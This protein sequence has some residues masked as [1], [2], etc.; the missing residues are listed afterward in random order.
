MEHQTSAL[1]RE[2]ARCNFV[3]E[4]D[5]GPERLEPLREKLRV[6]ARHLRAVADG[7]DGNLATASR[8]LW[9]FSLLPLTYIDDL[10]QMLKE[11]DEIV[12]FIDNWFDCENRDHHSGRAVIRGSLERAEQYLRKLPSTPEIEQAIRLLEEQG[13]ALASKSEQDRD[14][15]RDTF[16]EQVVLPARKA[17]DDAF[18]AVLDLIDEIQQKAPEPLR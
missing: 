4:H 2:H 8:R 12:S 17:L 6:A 5:A 15:D 1:A 18:Q 16:Y 13:A 3:D 11:L 10:G 9:L 14:Q 7:S